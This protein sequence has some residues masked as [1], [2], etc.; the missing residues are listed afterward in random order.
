MGGE[1]KRFCTA[2]VSRA[3][4]RPSLWL[5]KTR[6]DSA[7]A[8]ERGDLK[9]QIS[10]APAPTCITRMSG[11]SRRSSGSRSFGLAPCRRSRPRLLPDQLGHRV[12]VEPVV[13]H[14]LP[15]LTLFVVT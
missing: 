6:C 11:C 13:A 15:D 3:T 7:C 5:P 4:S 14:D 10:E 2:W 1:S 12:P 8:T 9:V